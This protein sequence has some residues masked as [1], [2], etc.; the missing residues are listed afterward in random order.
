MKNLIKSVLVASALV[1][2][3]EAYAQVRLGIKAGI[4]ASTIH[5][6]ALESGVSVEPQVAFQGG[7]LLDMPMTKSF[8]LQPAL[9][10]STKG[11]KVNSLLIDGNSGSVISPINNSIKLVYAEIPVLALFRGRISQSIRFYGG[12]GPYVGIGLGG[13]LSSSYA[14]IAERDVVFGSGDIGNNS[15]RRVDYGAS[16]AAGIEL[17]RLSVGV[18]YNYGLVDLGSALIKSYHRTLGITAGFWLAKPHL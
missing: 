12:V 4:N 10:I 14:P 1:L 7:V 15:F 16:A 17:K 8:S 3:N 2:G 6:P 13:R 11:S 9:L 18:N 5:I